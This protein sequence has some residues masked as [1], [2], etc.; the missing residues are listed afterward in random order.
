MCFPA[1]RRPA[2]EAPGA[3]SPLPAT[4]NAPRRRIAKTPAA[5]PK[6]TDTPA[7]T[8]GGAPADKAGD[9][10]GAQAAREAKAASEVSKKPKGT[11]PGRKS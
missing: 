3:P 10:G 11:R 8:G 7:Q 5:T 6:T 9:R 1:T 4:G 2:G